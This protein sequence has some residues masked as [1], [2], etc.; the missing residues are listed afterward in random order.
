LFYGVADAAIKAISVR[1]GAAGAGALLSGWGLLAVG[2][3]F[4]G[5]VSFQAAL[6]AGSAVASISL[7]NCLAALIALIAGLVG[8]GESL[9][10]GTAVSLVHVLAIGLVLACVP[11]LAAAQAELADAPQPVAT[12]PEISPDTASIDR[13]GSPSRQQTSRGEQRRLEPRTRPWA[14]RKKRVA[15]AHVARG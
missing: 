6:G 14:A 8:F 11:F 13:P 9:G 4:A 5:F 15:E 1:W 7:M 3:T 12:D 2:G 10:T